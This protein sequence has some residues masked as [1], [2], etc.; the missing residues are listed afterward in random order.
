MVS[1]LHMVAD[2][3]MF[4]PAYAEFRKSPEY[5][6]WLKS[7]QRTKTSASEQRPK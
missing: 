6:A 4:D 7:R 1:K 2:F 5:Q 3:A